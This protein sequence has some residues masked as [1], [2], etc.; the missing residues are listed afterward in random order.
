VRKINDAGLKLIKSFEGLKLTA[1]QDS[2]GVWTIGYGHTTGVRK[3]QTITAEE[4]EQFL[5]EDLT[6]ACTKVEELVKVPVLDN[7]FAALVSFVF[8]VG[9]WNFAKSTLLKKL[10]AFD[11]SG[12]AKEFLRWNKTDGKVLAGLTRRRKAESELFEAK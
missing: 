5:L 8:N 7:A 10:N 11:Y 4:A 1:Y 2:V 12:A 9:W 3:G 6:E